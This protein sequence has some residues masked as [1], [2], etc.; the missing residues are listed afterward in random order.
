M[1]NIYVV[2]NTPEIDAI[3]IK[4]LNKHDDF[5]SK[6]NIP[7]QAKLFIYQGQFSVGRGI[8]L[9]IEAFSKLDASKCHIV[10]MGFADG[11]Y[12]SLVNNA[13]ERHSNIHFQP[14]VPRDMIISYSACADIG[15]F[16]AEKVSLCD[17]MALPNKFFEWAHAGLPILVSKNLEYQ[18]SILK[19]R[20]FGWSAEIE[21]ITTVIENICNTE[22]SSYKKNAINY[23][24][25]NYWEND[26][27]VFSQIYKN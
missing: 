21:N 17:A 12:Q 23:A 1:D 20:G 4:P 15:I 11:N 22:I 6:F 3:K 16:I 27:K 7:D 18:A 8:E 5:R 14:A 9:L 24:S 2:K 13:V 19:D 25:E 26:A 10:F